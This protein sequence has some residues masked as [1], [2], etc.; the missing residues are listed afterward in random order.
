M[1]P[2]C[3]SLLCSL[4]RCLTFLGLPVRLGQIVPPDY[5]VVDHSFREINAGRHVGLL[6]STVDDFQNLDR[7]PHGNAVCRL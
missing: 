7:Q 5:L 6:C 4:P 3:L 1:L 2:Y